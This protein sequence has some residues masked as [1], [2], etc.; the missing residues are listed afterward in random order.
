MTTYTTICRLCPGACGVLAT[1][2]EGRLTEVTVD[3]TDPVSG[4]TPC[5]RLA[6]LPEQVHHPERI[7]QPL[8]RTGDTWEAVSWDTALDAIGE[9]LRAVRSQHGPA[10][11]G[12]YLGGERWS[13]SRETVR[14][15][16]VAAAAGTPHVFSE[17][18]EDSAPLLRVTEAMLG[19]PAVLLSDLSRAHYVVVF[20][21]QQPDSHW[22]PHRRGRTYTKA[23]AFSRR[24]KGTKLVVVGPQK[25]ALAE[26]ADQH[27]A[28]RPGTEPFF[29]LGML[30]AA[31]KGDWRDAQYV[32]D[33]T[34]GWD[35][36]VELVAPWPVERCAEICGVEAAR[37]SGVALK[38]GRAAMAIAHVDRTVTAGPNGSLGTWA[39]LALQTITANM[40]RP[41]G[42]Y[43]HQAP[44]DLHHPLAFVP[45]MKSP[46]TATGAPLTAL[47]VPAELLTEHVQQGV[48]GLV[49]IDADPV[50]SQSSAT[51]KAIEGTDVAVVLASRHSAT[52]AVADWVLPL[53][54]PLE[55]AELET[56]GG[57]ALPEPMVR[58]AP[59]VVSP[60]GEA[61]P[62]DQILAQLYRAL[63]PGLRGGAHGLHV[64]LAA[65]ALADTDLAEAERRALEW[66]ADV[67]PETLD[68]SPH[69]LAFGMADRSLWRVSQA[70]DRVHLAPD[71]IR[72]LLD[73]AQPPKATTDR[74]FFLHSSLPGGTVRVHPDTGLEDGA[75]I[76]IDTGHGTLD[77]TVH[78]DAE[79]RADTVVVPGDTPGLADILPSSPR[80]PFS[81]CPARDGLPAALRRR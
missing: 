7:T 31:V 3:P 1:V 28:I 71:A 46:S 26:Q 70:N 9:R 53:T 76:T 18:L 49:I 2:A 37:I 50:G 34:V 59:A 23:L 58:H 80:D 33:Y 25:A 11:L 48:R 77:L 41:G 42:L 24:T 44:L 35:A 27:I 69:R 66:V 10:A 60:P 4:G 6:E 12:F 75:A 29:L 65:R 21:G 52:T 32:R 67:D 38:F 30:S 72:P 15:L 20:G 63:K 17:Q 81:A 19:H 39:A 68:A 79:L 40:L 73:A 22:G 51:A 62:G 57:H 8:R 55:E 14:T 56:L 43:D 13:R 47:Q 16:M 5:S 54:H 64:A 45:A 36:L 61:R 78:L 74:P